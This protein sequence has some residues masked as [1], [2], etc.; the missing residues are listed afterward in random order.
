MHHK[1]DEKYKEKE[2]TSKMKQTSKG[3]VIKRLVIQER[4]CLFYPT[5]PES[6]LRFLSG[7]SGKTR[8]AKRHP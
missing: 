6:C 5:Q 1:G 7:P 2:K 4:P 3:G 8:M